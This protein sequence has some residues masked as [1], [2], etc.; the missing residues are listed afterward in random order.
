M[1][2][3]VEVVCLPVVD[4][5]GELDESDVKLTFHLSM[6]CTAYLNLAIQLDFNVIQEAQIK[7]LANYIS[8]ALLQQQTAAMIG[9]LDTPEEILRDVIFVIL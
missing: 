6:C 8:L 2:C 7:L 1:E 3:V 4:V 9:M 5:I